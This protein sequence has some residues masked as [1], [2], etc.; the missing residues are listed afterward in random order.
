[1][2]RYLGALQRQPVKIKNPADD[3]LIFFLKYQQETAADINAE[4]LAS[5]QL[6]NRERREIN[7]QHKLALNG[8]A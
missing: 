6:I 8:R 7:I 3:K 1:M 4:G 2:R 5:S